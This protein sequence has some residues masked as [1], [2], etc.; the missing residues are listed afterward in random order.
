MHGDGEPLG[1]GGD[2]EGA[3]PE[4]AAGPGHVEPERVVRQRSAENDRPVESTASRPR[5]AL[6]DGGG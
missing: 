2:V 3:K 1:I 6:T 5:P 4:M